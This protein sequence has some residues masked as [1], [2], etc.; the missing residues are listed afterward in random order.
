M[1]LNWYLGISYP[2]LPNGSLRLPAS[3]VENIARVQTKCNMIL[4]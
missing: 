1:F 2:P 4:R 3:S